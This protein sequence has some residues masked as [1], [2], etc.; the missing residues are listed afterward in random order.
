MQLRKNVVKFMRYAA[1]KNGAV[2]VT[3][4]SSIIDGQSHDAYHY[5]G[6]SWLVFLYGQH[7][8]ATVYK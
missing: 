8:R 5:R 6:T 7:H 2:G 4:K 1:R 3:L